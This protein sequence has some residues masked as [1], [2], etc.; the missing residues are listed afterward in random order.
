MNK[1]I[2]TIL[3]LLILS[4]KN[5]TILMS[6]ICGYLIGYYS[7]DIFRPT[8]KPKQEIIEFFV[9]YNKKYGFSDQGLK[10]DESI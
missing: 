8:K 6:F 3:F 5:F 4:E 1:K 2:L 9:S 10:K 7:F